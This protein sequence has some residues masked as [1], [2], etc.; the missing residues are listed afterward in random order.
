LGLP[1]RKYLW[2]LSREREIDSA[3][4]KA[5]LKIAHE[6]GYCTRELIWRQAVHPAL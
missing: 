5:L 4:R 2:L 6:P 3:G 1:E